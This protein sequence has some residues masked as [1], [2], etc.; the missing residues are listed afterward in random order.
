MYTMQYMYIHVWLLILCSS[1]LVDGLD[2]SLLATVIYHDIPTAKRYTVEQCMYILG[3]PFTTHTIGA[4]ESALYIEVFFIE[5]LICT[6]THLGDNR[7]FMEGCP[8]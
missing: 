8:L 5:R 3:N 4:N 6:E 2:D 1:P 7:F